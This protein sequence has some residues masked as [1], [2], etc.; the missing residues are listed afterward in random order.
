VIACLPPSVAKVGESDGVRAAVLCGEIP[1][2]VKAVVLN[3]SPWLLR[4]DLLVG[5]VRG[6]PSRRQ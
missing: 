2:V 1:D 3:R 5:Q 6:Y 4:S